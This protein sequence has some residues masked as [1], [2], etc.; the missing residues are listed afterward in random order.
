MDYAT[1]DGRPIR[2]EM[3]GS[4]LLI[5]IAPSAAPVGEF[6]FRI[7]EESDGTECGLVVGMR[8]E[9]TGPYGSFRRQGIGRRAL[10]FVR[11]E[12]GILPAFRYPD[13]QRWDDGSHLIDDGPM[14]ASA[15]VSEGLAIWY[16]APT[17]TF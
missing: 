16:N 11:A 7:I 6:V 14:F 13:G 12:E 4:M 10:E 17:D 8:L 1:N 2:F 15:M 3:A 9:G 5:R